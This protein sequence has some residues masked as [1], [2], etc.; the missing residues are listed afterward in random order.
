MSP[1]PTTI[2]YLA[3]VIDSDGYITASSSTRGG[4]T[5]CAPRVGISGTRREPHDLAASI[6]GGT[7]RSYEPKDDRS[8]HR[9][10]YQWVLE[11]DGAAT[12][13]A[14]VL[15][16]LLVKRAQAQLALQ[17]QEARLEARAARTDEDSYPWAPS[18]YDPTP[19]MVALAEDIRALNVR[20]RELD[21]RTWDEFPA[22]S[23]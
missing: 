9:T 1:E 21:G 3:G 12:V 19:A 6:Y 18:G 13:I 7:V 15:P 20:G 4:R 16:Y 8:H 17:L 11:G 14:A 10:Q 22:V 23:A 2:A 5:Y